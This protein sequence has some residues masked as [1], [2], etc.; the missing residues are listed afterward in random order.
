MAHEDLFADKLYFAFIREVS[1]LHN[2]DTLNLLLKK[3]LSDVDIL[4]LFHLF[5]DIKGLRDLE[6][7]SI[8]SIDETLPDKEY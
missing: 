6:I 2:L 8:D 4:N 3:G 5:S 1:K 7:S